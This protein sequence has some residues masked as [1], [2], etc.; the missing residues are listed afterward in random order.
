METSKTKEKG[1]QNN[2]LK[3]LE[4]KDFWWGLM[5][6]SLVNWQVRRYK[7][8]IRI[9]GENENIGKIFKEIIDDISVI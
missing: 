8:G 2:S 1:I 9:I 7:N 3:V 4:K 5:K 6:Y